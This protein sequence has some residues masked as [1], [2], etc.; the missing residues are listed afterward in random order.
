MN[1][2][3]NGGI[4]PVGSDTGV[5]ETTPVQGGTPTASLYPGAADQ[6]DLGTVN[7]LHANVTNWP[8]TSKITDVEIGSD[9]ITIDHTKAGKWPTFN[10]GGIE[11]EGNPWVFVNRNGRWYGATY[12][13]LRP[14]QTEKAVTGNDIG[15]NIKA[16]PLATWTPQPG[17]LVG[18]MVSTPARD[19]N[20]TSNERS[21]VVMTRWPA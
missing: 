3:M 12:D 17:E 9:S 4:A 19:G 14:G 1:F 8:I 2:T 21:N 20:R 6:L 15:E 11:I 16:E 5:G 13:W 10:Y 7:W 18:F